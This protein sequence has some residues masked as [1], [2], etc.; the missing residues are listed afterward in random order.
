M[1]SINRSQ[2]DPDKYLRMTFHVADAAGNIV[3]EKQTAASEQMNWSMYWEGNNRIVLEINGI[4]TYAWERQPDGRWIES[5]NI[6][7]GAQ[8]ATSTSNTNRRKFIRR[9]NAMDKRQ[10]GAIS[11]QS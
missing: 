5:V 6:F 2:A 8:G 10:F 1:T 9:R 11:S 4:G 3:Y 7:T